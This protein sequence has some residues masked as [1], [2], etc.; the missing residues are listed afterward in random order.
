[1]FFRG[2][3]TR[4][5]LAL[6]GLLAVAAIGLDGRAGVRDEP[7]DPWGLGLASD[8][9]SARIL[10]ETLSIGRGDT[11][12]DLLLEARVER[13]EAERAIRALARYYSP[14]TLQIGQE[15]T[16]VL[17]PATE[18]EDSATLLAIGL[19]VGNGRHVVAER[20]GASFEARRGDSS[21]DMARVAAAIEDVRPRAEPVVPGGGPAAD[22]VL[23]K[24][25]LGRGDTLLGRLVAA[26]AESG[27]ALSAVK[28]LRRH[29]DLNALQIGQELAVRLEGDDKPRLAS[30]SL[31][32]GDDVL[33]A[34]RTEDG[35]FGIGRGR[36]ALA[37]AVPGLTADPFA[38]NG[39]ADPVVSLAPVPHVPAG[40][41]LIVIEKVLRIGRG[42]TLM[43][44]LEHAGAERAEALAAIE[45]IARF[46]SPRALHV[47][48]RV[49][50]TFAPAG[51][52]GVGTLIAMRLDTADASVRTTRGADGAFS[53][54]P[55]TASLPPLPPAA[56]PK[57]GAAWR[58]AAPES[59]DPGL[60]S[61]LIEQAFEIGPGDTL[62]QILAGAGASE[63]DA[64]A[65]VRALRKIVNPRRLRIG[66]EVAVIL[67]PEDFLSGRPRLIGV[68][69]ERGPGDYA[70]ASRV[71]GAYEVRL[72]RSAVTAATF[73]RPAPTESTEVDTASPGLPPIPPEP[74]TLAAAE[75]RIEM[76][77]TVRK[78]DTL[79]T[80]LTGAGATGSDAK[81][82]V[83][84]LRRVFNPR[85]LK[86]GQVITLSFA[87]P[88]AGAAARLIGLSLTVEPG[89]VAEVV[90][91]GDTSFAAY[92]RASEL[93]A[94]LLR[95]EGV[96]DSSLYQAANDAG[97]PSEIM[98]DLIAAFSYD[99]DFQRDLRRGD[100]FEV[101][102]RSM[103]DADGNFVRYESPL[104]AS[105]EVG[106][107]THPIYLYAALGEALD[108]YHADGTSVR[109]ALLRTPISGA[110]V[111]S[112]FGK[113][114]DPFQGFTKMH[115]GID[116]GAPKG[117]P[118][119]AAGDGTIVFA[120]KFKG[121]GKYVRVRH[122]D[123]FETAY[124]H[125]SKIGKGI[126]KGAKVSQG[127]IIGYVGCTGRCTGNHLHYEVLLAGKQVDPN[128]VDLPTG[129]KLE[130]V[131]LASF[132][133]TRIALDQTFASLA[134]AT[135]V[136]VQP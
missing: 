61:S 100:R 123:G 34:D 11:L 81:A 58:L 90:R 116:F 110:R 101:L 64:R 73:A 92:E 127:Q 107:R 59:A 32:L 12:M 54:E 111:T 76:P 60:A 43:R 65:A 72:D 93:G 104:Y 126:K 132:F 18:P 37:L 94:T 87:P 48:D 114:K 16:V 88:S 49:T 36:Q 25:V 120:G 24:L 96:I 75:G 80:A 26:G 106:G 130:G 78:G 3:R 125:M 19:A 17:G 70:I 121:Y 33:T 38:D 131:E 109:K 84:E 28:A 112:S 102:Y 62:L 63:A 22:P 5:V 136:A 39:D 21:V 103:T 113:R 66:N 98:N 79:L 29:V 135:Q 134:S 105:L 89:K 42:D 128:G 122:N 47:G 40:D 23:L 74:P 35:G 118:V 4:S 14:R 68:S 56:A 1:M 30:V 13:A 119:L 27:D 71:D 6:C 77:F 85:R 31:S 7:D 8:T 86:P 108:Y 53:A 129:R 20:A 133:E 82:V 2:K 99:V 69:V 117:T 41:G 44:V 50:A 83:D 15:L 115:K 10:V 95:A 45:A 55:Y 46:V 9:A 97:V 124:A 57:A 52:G 91:R 67:D 51:D